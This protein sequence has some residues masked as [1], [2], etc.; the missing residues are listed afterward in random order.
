[1]K[2]DSDMT[3]KERLNALLNARETFSF[4][5]HC[6]LHKF[7]TLD[8]GEVMTQNST[9]DRQERLQS[10]LQERRVNQV[11]VNRSEKDGNIPTQ[12][13][14]S[15]KKKSI[16]TLEMLERINAFDESLVNIDNDTSFLEDIVK[17]FQNAFPIDPF[18]V[19]CTIV[20]STHDETL[21]Q[22]IDAAKIEVEVNCNL[23]CVYEEGKTINLNQTK[24]ISRESEGGEEYI[25]DETVEFTFSHDDLFQR[26]K[27]ILI[28]GQKEECIE[29]NFSSLSN[30]QPFQTLGSG[31]IPIFDATSLSSHLVLPAMKSSS[32][33]E[34]ISLFENSKMDSKIGKAQ[35]QCWV[36][37]VEA[38]L[39]AHVQ[40][41][42]ESA[43]RKEERHGRA[44]ELLEISRFE[45]EPEQ[46]ILLEH[47]VKEAKMAVGKV[48]RIA[49][50][51][52]RYLLQVLGAS[53]RCKENEGSK[54]RSSEKNNNSR[55]IDSKEPLLREV[56]K[57]RKGKTL[58]WSELVQLEKKLPKQS[59]RKNDEEKKIEILYQKKS[60]KFFSVLHHME[61]HQ[62]VTQQ[63][64]NSTWKGKL[65]LSHLYQ[66]TKNEFLQ[67]T[68]KVEERA[69]EKRKK[70]KG[71]INENM[72]RFS[73]EI[74]AKRGAEL[75]SFLQSVPV[76]D[77]RVLLKNHGRFAYD[78]LNGKS[79]IENDDLPSF[80]VKTN[81]FAKQLF[82]KN[83]YQEK[84]NN[85]GSR[86]I[87]QSKNEMSDCLEYSNPSLSKT[88]FERKKKS[89]NVTNKDEKSDDDGGSFGILQ[90][91][92]SGKNK[93]CKQQMEEKKVNATQKEKRN[94]LE[95]KTFKND[96]DM[97]AVPHVTEI[98]DEQRRKE[99]EDFFKLY[100]EIEES[101]SRQEV[102]LKAI[103]SIEDMIASA[104]FYS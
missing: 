85:R 96:V 90:F 59:K 46:L 20:S 68:K 11:Q 36:E 8:K 77:D 21:L 26:V 92:L 62:Y 93:L 35:V 19:C 57:D 91:L 50:Q 65:T 49:V 72:N 87:Y 101:S 86:S 100:T 82:P 69:E 43:K 28:K 88:V 45:I 15:Q 61:H 18:K 99:N 47:S 44:V 14:D 95:R 37:N 102:S 104:R 84:D 6:N 76:D 17:K 25:F 13:G 3:A 51:S 78:F 1:M 70:L 97:R 12:L 80:Q 64:K 5:Q 31:Q 103:P 32:R 71:M 22:F 40:S 67:V 83:L 58:S 30:A 39:F 34:E 75:L 7:R 24:L 38:L 41:L 16:E 48:C 66:N 29:L 54:N 94:R 74:Y 53:I 56:K 81:D 60:N 23:S 89:I 55:F 9:D 10:I 73:Y 33:L 52:I 4:A 79:T 63:T 98:T 27:R 2:V 42:V